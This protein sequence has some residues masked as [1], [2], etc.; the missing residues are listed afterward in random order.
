MRGQAQLQLRESDQQ[1]GAQI[2]IALH[3]R[4]C[5]PRAQGRIEARAL[6]QCGHHDGFDQGAVACIR[7]R[8]QSR[9]QGC[10]QRATTVQHLIE[11]AGG[12]HSAGDAGIHAIQSRRALQ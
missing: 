2:A 10:F 12:D 3:E 9:A 6:A 7:Q 1:Q 11:D 8:R 5:Q 4:L